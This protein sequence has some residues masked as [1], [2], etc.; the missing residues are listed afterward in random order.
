MKRFLSILIL[1]FIITSTFSTTLYL[2]SGYNGISKI[3]FDGK[4]WTKKQY[5]CPPISTSGIETTKYLYVNLRDHGFCIIDKENMSVLEQ[6]DTFHAED[7]AFDINKLKFYIA[8]GV[9]MGIYFLER[10]SKVCFRNKIHFRGWISHVKL[11]G[12]YIILAS[13]YE[14][15]YLVKECSGR[16]IILDYLGRTYN[17]PLEQPLT[18]MNVRAY[19]RT[20]YIAAKDGLHLMRV[21]G[22]RLF[23]ELKL[24]DRVSLDVAVNSSYIAVAEPLQKRVSLFLTSSREKI[25]E[26]IYPDQ[27]SAIELIHDEITEKIFVAAIVKGIGLV[28]D[29]PSAGNRWIIGGSYMGF[30]RKATVQ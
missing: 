18:T 1:L 30:V 28:I 27:P 14:G 15:I 23:H 19:G 9:G 11:F 24:T 7:I 20:I 29:E 25:T 17:D 8:D 3:T 16:Y 21:K 13:L 4:E 10:P 12:D 5:Y 26:I 22:N 2:G 6:V